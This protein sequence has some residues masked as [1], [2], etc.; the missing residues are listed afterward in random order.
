M[1]TNIDH[2]GIAAKSIDRAA[3]F[4]RDVLGLSA[5]ARETVADQNVATLSLPVGE[6]EIEVLE[7][8]APDGAV[9]RFIDSRGEGVQHIA[10]RVDNIDAALKE[11]KARGIR[12][13]DEKPRCGAGGSRIAFI[14]PESTHG[15]LLE[16][17]ERAHSRQ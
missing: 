16:L 6:S 12:L 3:P 15:I 8:T 2:I 13:I 4:W 5:G 9:A 10:F 17:V 14:H 11:L 1:I 7:S